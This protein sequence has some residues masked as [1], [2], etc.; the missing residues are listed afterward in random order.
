MPQMAPMNWIMLYMMFSI[1]FII[2]NLMNYYIFITEKKIIKT[3]FFIK[4]MLEWKW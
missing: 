3:N 1:I 2:F 4:K